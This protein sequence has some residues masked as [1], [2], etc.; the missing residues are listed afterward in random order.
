MRAQLSLEFLIA[1]L[2]M[3]TAL[4]LLI[5]AVGKPEKSSLDRISAQ[6]SAL[7]VSV[8][9][10]HF[11]YAE[12]GVRIGGDFVVVGEQGYPVV[13]RGGNHEET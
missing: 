8:L 3:F 1:V 13:N 10:S 9:R 5:P 6:E 11:N 12:A 4:A 2:I 7:V